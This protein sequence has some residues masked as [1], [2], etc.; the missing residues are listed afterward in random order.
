MKHLTKY[1]MLMLSLLPLFSSCSDDDDKG[2]DGSPVVVAENLQPAMFGDSLTFN[3]NCSDAAGVPLSTLKAQLCY[4]DEVVN[5]VTLR[6]KTE[7]EYTVKLYA[8]FYKDVPDGEA[9]V[10]LALQNTHLAITSKTVTVEL[11]RPHYEYVNLMSSDGK[12]FKLTPDTNDPYLF[13]GTVTSTSRSITG[14]VQTPS[15][16]AANQPQT[17]GLGTNGVTQGVTDNITFA[18]NSAGTFEVWF[19][20]MTYEFGPQSEIPI[21]T[22]TDAEDANIYVGELTQNGV[23]EITGSDKFAADSWYYDPDFFQ[24]NSDGTFTFTAMSGLYTVKADF[25]NNGFKIWKMADTENTATLA[26]DGS[27]ALW[28]IGSDCICKPTYAQITG[29]GWWTDT[30]HAL[31]LAPVKDK[32]YQLTLT[33]GK[34]LQADGKNLNFKFFGQAGWGIE[35]K[36]TGGSYY[37]TTE[38]DVFAVGD[39]TTEYQ[40]GHDDGNIYLRPGVTLKDGDTYVLTVDL[41]AGTDKAK[42]IVEKK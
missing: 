12:V 23:Y 24:K 10:R 38:S 26:A 4:G 22:L 32:V 6:T 2:G 33:V 34:Q 31:C 8:P 21:I 35:F 36:G 16:G 15:C 17:F 14:Y 29:Q 18:S 27:G 9:E 39:G 28:V 30:D 40:G 37:L 19:N 3:V 7:G 13:K 41:T 42:L 25:T 1:I 20:V 5:E 11:S